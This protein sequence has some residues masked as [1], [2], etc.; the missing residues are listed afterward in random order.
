MDALLKTHLSL[1]PDLPLLLLPHLFREFQ[2]ATRAVFFW[3][4][5]YEKGFS[6]MD[7]PTP[8]GEMKTVQ[9]GWSPP[10]PRG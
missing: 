6:T 2:S 5:D 1:G 3:R 10:A 4:D 9:G 7:E 8:W